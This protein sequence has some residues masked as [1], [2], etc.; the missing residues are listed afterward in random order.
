MFLLLTVAFEALREQAVEEGAAVVAKRGAAVSVA[1][2]AVFRAISL[3]SRRNGQLG[4][5]LVCVASGNWGALRRA[6]VCRTC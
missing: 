4:M 2:E 5:V 6:N 1:L 3:R